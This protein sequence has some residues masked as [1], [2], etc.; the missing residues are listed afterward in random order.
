MI[1]RTKCLEAMLQVA[2]VLPKGQMVLGRGRKERGWV[3]FIFLK[4]KR[5]NIIA[6][7]KG[8]HDGNTLEE[9]KCLGQRDIWQCEPASLPFSTPRQPSRSP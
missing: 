3:G 5:V 1:L 9:Y 6:C 4:G 8:C 2:T 7:L